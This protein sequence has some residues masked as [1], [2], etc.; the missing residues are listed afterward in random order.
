MSASSQT[1]HLTASG[2]YPL[3]VS[4]R[5]LV[6][7]F[8]MHTHDHV[9]LF[10]VMNGSAVH[11]VESHRYFIKAGDVYVLREGHAH[12]FGSVAS[13]VHYNIG[14]GPRLLSALGDELGALDGF[15]RLFVLASTG[16]GGFL[17]KLQLSAADVYGSE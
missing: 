17:A 15:Q 6:R 11:T 2:A 1:I 13:L 10:I 16:K 12:S 4:R 3:E 8:G 14:F 7:D 9:E 5:M